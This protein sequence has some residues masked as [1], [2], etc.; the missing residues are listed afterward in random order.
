MEFTLLPS[1]GRDYKSKAAVLADWNNGKD[2]TIAITGQQCS[3][4]DSKVLPGSQV[5]LRYNKKTQIVYVKLNK[6]V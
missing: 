6:E 3:I 2:F 4:R 1:Y 5:G